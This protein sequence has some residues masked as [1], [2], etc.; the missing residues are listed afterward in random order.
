MTQCQGCM[1]F[2]DPSLVPVCSQGQH[3]P[4]PFGTIMTMTMSLFLT[5]CLWASHSFIQLSM[6]RTGVIQVGPEGSLP[7]RNSTDS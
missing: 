1:T 4:H 3:R 6:A 7:L 2:G 5:Y